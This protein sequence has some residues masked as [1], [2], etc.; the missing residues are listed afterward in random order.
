MGGVSQCLV[1]R[2]ARSRLIEILATIR[3][4]R[5]GD[6]D[7]DAA[8]QLGTA[9]VLGDMEFCLVEFCL[10]EVWSVTSV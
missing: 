6:G 9:N 4:P 2:N 7:G 3:S 5:D 8:W 10:V 1:K